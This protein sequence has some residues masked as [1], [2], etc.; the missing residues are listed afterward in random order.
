M[1]WMRIACRN[2]SRKR[3]RKLSRE[4]GNAFKIPIS[5]PSKNIPIPQP[6]PK[7]PNPRPFPKYPYPPAPF[8]FK[9]ARGAKAVEI[10]ESWI[11]P[12][13]SPLWKG[14]TKGGY[15]NRQ[16]ISRQAF[17]IPIPQPCPKYPY[18]RPFPFHK[19]QGSKTWK[20]PGIVDISW[21]FPPL[22]R[23]DEGGI[24]DQA[25]IFSKTFKNP[26][27][28]PFQK[29]PYPQPQNIPIPGPSPFKR[30]RERNPQEFGNRGKLV[31]FP[32]F[33]K[34]GYRGDIQKSEN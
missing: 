16:E 12:G 32:P 7:Y 31:D 2:S 9:R 27:P 17:N 8:P 19:G 3:F 1:N 26:Y 22:E 10:R 14:G 23:G 20:I 24:L 15:W 33:G 25:I 11:F 5:G 4:N 18:P 28:Q 6:F 30:G 34:G 29:Y 21:I 13:F